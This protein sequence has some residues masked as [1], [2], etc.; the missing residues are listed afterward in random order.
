MGRL[1]WW[2]CACLTAGLGILCIFAWWGWSAAVVLV[3]FG[4]LVAAVVASSVWSGDDVQGAGR[5]IATTT[6]AGAVLGPA[7]AGLIA[8]LG[9]AGLLI[10]LLLAVTMPSLTARVRARWFTPARPD[11]TQPHEALPDETQPGE[12]RPHEAQSG[13]PQ[14]SEPQANDAQ[15][16]ETHPDE[17]QPG[18][19]LPHEAQSGEMQPGKTQAN[20]AQ[21][22]E[23]QPNDVQPGEPRPNDGQPS[24]T[25]PNDVQPGE[26]RPNDAR[27]GEVWP[28]GS[29]SEDGQ[30][31]AAQSGAAELA[32]LDDEALCLEWRRSFFRLEAASTAGERLAVVQER[33]RYLDELHRRSPDGLAAWFA[34]GARASGDPLPYVDETR[35]RP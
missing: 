21:P 9:S 28:V 24:E 13:G 23:T 16:G 34:S 25:Q 32:R 10:A 2:C 11:E 17:T 26:S 19:P 8:A 18:A 20:D 29:R 3:A 22:D 35:R 15:P 12:T 14:P 7:V 5:K 6:G 30:G 1:V 27:P 4:T 33:Q 31:T